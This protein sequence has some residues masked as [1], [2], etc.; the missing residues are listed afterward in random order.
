[1]NTYL[2]DLHWLGPHQKS[3]NTSRMES[4]CSQCIFDGACRPNSC[5]E[6]NFNFLF[7]LFFSWYFWKTNSEFAQII[8][9]CLSIKTSTWNCIPLFA[10]GI[11]FVLLSWKFIGKN[12]L[13][14][15]WDNMIHA[16]QTHPCNE[17]RVFPVYAFFTGKNLFSLQVFP[18]KES[19]HRENPVFITGMGL[20]CI[21]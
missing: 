13:N 10:N 11:E 3:K 6:T 18:C 21:Q 2:P 20:Q 8:F 19:V 9:I 1:M 17:N 15:S 12:V 16:L 4:V 5:R 7:S 14:S